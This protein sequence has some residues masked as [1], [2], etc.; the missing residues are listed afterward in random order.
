MVEKLLFFIGGIFIGN[1]FSLLSK[2]D[3]IKK[4][5]LKAYLETYEMVINKIV[6]LATEIEKVEI[7]DS[8]KQELINKILAINDLA[9]VRY[10]IL[11]EVEK[12]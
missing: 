3:L 10:Q 4:V 8:L 7:D 12:K 5:Y 6:I 2:F 1:V 9:R 11:K